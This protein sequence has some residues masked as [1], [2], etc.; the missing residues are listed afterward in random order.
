M[1]EYHILENLY[2]VVM[3][4]LV[5][6]SFRLNNLT[7]SAWI[8]SILWFANI[9]IAAFQIV[10]L[11]EPKEIGILS[12]MTVATSTYLLLNAYAFLKVAQ[13]MHKK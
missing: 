13:H 8:Q 2:L 9:I 4:L 10:L 12:L 7:Y 5:R 1:K 3:A 6:F 11:E